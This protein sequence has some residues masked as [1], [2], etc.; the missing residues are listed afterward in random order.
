MRNEKVEE[1]EA[2]GKKKENGKRMEE[3][4]KRER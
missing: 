2:E 1:D 4:M 3:K